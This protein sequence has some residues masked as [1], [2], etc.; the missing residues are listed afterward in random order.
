[1]ESRRNETKA[2][3]GFEPMNNGFA[4]RPLKPLGYAAVSHT[5]PYLKTANFATFFFLL[6]VRSIN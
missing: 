2:A 4:N 6:L 1:M 5:I 3:I